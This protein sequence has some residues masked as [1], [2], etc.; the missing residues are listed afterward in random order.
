MLTSQ[1]YKYQISKNKFS[2]YLLYK[3]KL[4]I[5][6]LLFNEKLYLKKYFKVEDYCLFEAID[7]SVV[8]ES[9]DD[10][11]A[12][13]IDQI[14]DVQSACGANVRIGKRLVQSAHKFVFVGRQ[15]ERCVVYRRRSVAYVSAH[16][17]RPNQMSQLVFVE[18]RLQTLERHLLIYIYSRLLFSVLIY[19]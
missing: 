7:K 16:T 18:I 15:F 1:T 10:L 6:K 11:S 17:M 3:L 2:N 19:Q 8:I 14:N 12:L 9:L 5:K 4:I 13:G